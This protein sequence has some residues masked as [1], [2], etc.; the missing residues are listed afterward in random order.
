MAVTFYFAVLHAS[1][2][3]VNFIPNTTTGRM[4]SA[5]ST[6]A[7]STFVGK[8]WTVQRCTSFRY[9]PFDL[10]SRYRRKRDYATEENHPG[11]KHRWTL[12]EP[13]HYIV[14][15]LAICGGCVNWSRH[16]E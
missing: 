8:I 4:F 1:T 7:M 11:Y 2:V 9:S 3:N 13:L 6:A 16:D 15:H 14:M 12:F 5:A 10:V